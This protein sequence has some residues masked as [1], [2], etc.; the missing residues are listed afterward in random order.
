MGSYGIANL[1]LGD[2]SLQSVGGIGKISFVAFAL[3]GKEIGEVGVVEEFR[4][5]PGIFL[6]ADACRDR[7]PNFLELFEQPVFDLGEHLMGFLIDDAIG[8]GEFELRVGKEPILKPVQRFW[9]G[10]AS[11]AAE[12]PPVC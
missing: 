12:V 1:E 8:K 9:I 10:E 3:S 7:S 2:A 4:S 6:I 11:E 5:R